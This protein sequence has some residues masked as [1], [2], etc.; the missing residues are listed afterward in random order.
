MIH[1][2]HPE[3]ISQLYS[4]EAAKTWF[5]KQAIDLN[6]LLIKWA[7]KPSKKESPQEGQLI[8]GIILDKWDKLIEILLKNNNKPEARNPQFRQSVGRKS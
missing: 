2:D 3:E 5:A 7:P 1:P 8:P 4:G 6:T